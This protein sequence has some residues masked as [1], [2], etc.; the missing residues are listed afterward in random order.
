MK[1]S[2]GRKLHTL[3]FS[4]NFR[5]HTKALDALI[6]GVKTRD[7]GSAFYGAE[8]ESSFDLLLKWTTLRF[9]ETNPKVLLKTMTFVKVSA[10]GALF[11]MAAFQG[12]PL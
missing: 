1:G 10:A 8:A 12:A 3:L 7:S 6:D 11:G 9:L 2:V 5:D 4:D